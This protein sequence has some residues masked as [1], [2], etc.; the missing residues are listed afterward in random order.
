MKIVTLLTDFGL[1]DSYVAQIKGVILT[2]H[3]DA[4]LIDIT[5]EVP[6][7]DILYASRSLAN[8]WSYFPK[9]TVHMV[10]VDPAVGTRRE[11]LVAECNGHF[12][13]A[14]DNGVLTLL[15][16]N[17]TA[18][19]FNINLETIRVQNPSFT[20][21]G[22]DVFAPAVNS[23]L[24]GSKPSDMGLI[25][26]QIR[27]MNFPAP[28]VTHDH[29]E[30]EIISFDHYG[31]MVTNITREHMSGFDYQIQVGNIMIGKMAKTYADMTPG[32]L[33]ALI[34]SSGYLELS[35]SGGSARDKFNFARGQRVKLLKVH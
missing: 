17:P 19:F 33:L 1:S 24:S 15:K 29:I 5:H 11:R 32:E 8:T 4:R 27:E 13:V 12:F 3:P 25:M 23:L 14:P 28:V 22:R 16:L 18:R 20:F 10:I 31:N 21:E 30:G 35:V 26:Q 2:Q 7:Q 9:G 34:N 6:P